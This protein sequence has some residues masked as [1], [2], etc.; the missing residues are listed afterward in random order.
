MSCWSARRNKT[1]RELQ[2]EIL[3]IYLD[4]LAGL[5]KAGH[6][7]ARNLTV[8]AFNIFGVINWSLRWYRPDG[9]LSPHEVNNEIIGFILG[10]VG[11][12]G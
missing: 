6:V 9:R 10:G 11:I 5:K 3:D 2:R 12:A 7:R 8:T 1:N 4:E